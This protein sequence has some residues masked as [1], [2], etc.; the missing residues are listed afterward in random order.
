M[1]FVE[2]YLGK[3]EQEC[4]I[5]C[6]FVDDLFCYVIRLLIVFLISI[7][8]SQRITLPLPWNLIWMFLLQD[9]CHPS[10]TIFS[11]YRKNFEKIVMLKGTLRQ[12]ML[13]MQLMGEAVF[14]TNYFF[15]DLLF[16]F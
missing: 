9:L 15:S 4:K 11:F 13:I 7:S 10:R 16:T 12:E 6:S 5:F 8:F 14:Y 1:F 3:P 2:V